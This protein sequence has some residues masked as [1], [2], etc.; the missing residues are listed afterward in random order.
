MPQP[1]HVGPKA[2]QMPSGTRCLTPGQRCAQ[3]RWAVESMWVRRFMVVEI[4]T[5]TSSRA[6]L[7]WDHQ[8]QHVQQTRRRKPFA[9][10][11]AVD[12]SVCADFPI[13][14]AQRLGG[15]LASQH[16]SHSAEVSLD[17]H[18]VVGQKLRLGFWPGS[19]HVAL[20]ATAGPNKMR[21]GR[22]HGG[23]ARDPLQQ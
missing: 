1:W 8:R 9:R 5:L 13:R 11:R 6:A 19:F 21:R 3:I 22:G 10:N 2:V 18:M 7:I 17:K 20:H 16:G 12:Q 23:A 4:R 14:V 15:R